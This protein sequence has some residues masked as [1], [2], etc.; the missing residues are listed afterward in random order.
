MI[1]A[2][3]GRGG[4]AAAHP[5]PSLDH[6]GGVARHVSHRCGFGSSCAVREGNAGETGRHAPVQRAQQTLTPR[7]R[8]PTR[9]LPRWRRRGV[10]HAH[11]SQRVACGRRRARRAPR[12]RMRAPRRTRAGAPRAAATRRAPR[13]ARAPRAPYCRLEGCCCRLL[14]RDARKK[15]ALRACTLTRRVPA[16]LIISLTACA[17]H[18][19]RRQRARA[20]AGAPRDTQTIDRRPAASRARR[21][22]ARAEASL[23][24]LFFDH[25]PRAWAA[26]HRAL[27][28]RGNAITI[29]VTC[30]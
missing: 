5:P 24:R 3:G 9:L 26:A 7:R 27:P 23:P 14:L 10:L 2:L 6:D 21:G 13:A 22:A 19:R 17:Y 1:P 20:H 25:E 15:G 8:P 11:C 29:R 30:P 4:P 12:R 18:S 16:T 28:R